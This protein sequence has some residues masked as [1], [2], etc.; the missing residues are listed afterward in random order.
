MGFVCVEIQIRI[1]M[2][3]AKKHGDKFDRKSAIFGINDNQGR[4]RTRLYGYPF[5]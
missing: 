1:Y 4:E 2:R 3:D 5:P